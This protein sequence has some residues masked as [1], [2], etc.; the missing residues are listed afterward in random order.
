MYE[1]STNT[2]ST[3]PAPN[4]VTKSKV[5]S[6]GLI[7]GVVVGIVV[8]MAALSL[9]F[10]YHGRSNR[11]KS[12]ANQDIAL[13]GIPRAGQDKKT[14]YLFANSPLPMHNKLH[15][16]P[17]FYS[18]HKTDGEL[19]GGEI[20]QLPDHHHNSDDYAILSTRMESQRRAGIAREIGGTPVMYEMMGD[21]PTPME[22][23]DERS[24]KG[25]LL[26]P[27]VAELNQ[28]NSRNS[29]RSRIAGPVPDC[30]PH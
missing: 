2:T 7:A 8:I 20:Y 17:S 23:D 28:E 11:A 26:S 4:A 9:A 25:L 27:G 18:E 15:E 14:R 21:L 16:A 12:R 30:L 5:M 29:S 3:S 10:F 1:L 24:R 6:P 19:G 13:G 22:L